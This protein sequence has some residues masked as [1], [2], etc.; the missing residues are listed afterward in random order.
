MALSETAIKA[1]I[2]DCDGTCY[3]TENLSYR[4]WRSLMC[5]CGA[6]PT[7]SFLQ[8]LIGKPLQLGL[9]EL[10]ALLPRPVPL[11]ILQ[12]SLNELYAKEL[13]KTPWLEKPGLGQL[14][15]FLKESKIPT[16]MASSS[17]RSWVLQLL[18]SRQGYFT[19]IVTIEDV[20][21][22]KPAPDPFL[23]AARRLC[24][25]PAECLAVE[26]SGAGIKSAVAAGMRVIYVPDVARPD[27][28]ITAL[29]WR[30]SK[31]LAE[32]PEILAPY[33]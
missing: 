7:D 30:T 21:S 13:A 2:L 23:E 29:A 19:A 33:F 9:A 25:P 22:S 11:E 28:E 17:D 20:I 32:L 3:D 1:V 16:A 26:D 14:L 31:S 24:L 10:L 6:V 8:G 5:Q 12:G 18:G 27:P 15:S 4:V